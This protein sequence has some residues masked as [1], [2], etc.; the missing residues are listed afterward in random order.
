MLQMLA[1]VTRQNFA[2]WVS[3]LCDLEVGAGAVVEST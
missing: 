2:A 1:Q 3:L